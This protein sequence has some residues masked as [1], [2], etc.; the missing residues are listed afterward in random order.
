MKRIQT[1]Q[2]T[3][4]FT[5][6]ISFLPSSCQNLFSAVRRGVPVEFGG[7]SALANASGYT[8]V[9]RRVSEGAQHSNTADFHRHTRCA[10]NKL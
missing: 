3:V 1:V 4:V 7:R 10:A 8:G 9:A 2:D 5:L 6:C